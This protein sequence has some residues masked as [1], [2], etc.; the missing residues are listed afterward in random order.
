[1][2]PH[3]ILKDLNE[4]KYVKRIRVGASCVF[5]PFNSRIGLK[6]YGRRYIQRNCMSLQQKAYEAGLAPKVREEFKFESKNEGFIAENKNRLYGTFLQGETYWGEES[7]K[8]YK[9]YGYH[10]D[11]VSVL[12]WI[13]DWFPEKGVRLN[14]NLIWTQSKYYK[15][16]D[17]LQE[18][19][20]EI[21][22]SHGDLVTRNLGWYKDHLVCIDF[23][24]NS[25]C[26]AA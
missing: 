23:D 2:K 20:Y 6:L 17:K 11:R 18:K 4:N 9:I 12:S 14:K 10:T 13:N 25:C 15:E 26:K 22:I 8:T 21:G 24:F 16:V 3:P 19:L 1:M 5:I 7:K